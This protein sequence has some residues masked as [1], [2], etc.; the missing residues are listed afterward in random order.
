MSAPLPPGALS[1]LAVHQTHLRVRHG[2]LVPTPGHSYSRLRSE[3][4]TT[5][6]AE[7]GDSKAEA[8]A[9]AQAVLSA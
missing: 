2:R 6:V 5:L 9:Q 8:S 4:D 3:A 1:A 7:G